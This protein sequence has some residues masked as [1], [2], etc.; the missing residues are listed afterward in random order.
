MHLFAEFPLFVTNKA[1]NPA[2]SQEFY[3][4]IDSGSLILQFYSIIG[5]AKR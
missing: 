5:H 4:G 2:F 1:K 3:L